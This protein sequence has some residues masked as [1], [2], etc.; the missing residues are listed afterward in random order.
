MQSSSSSSEFFAFGAGL[1]A[2]PLW[3]LGCLPAAVLADCALPGTARKAKKNSNSEQKRNNTHRILFICQE[4]IGWVRME[5]LSLHRNLSLHGSLISKQQHFFHLQKK[6]RM[7]IVLGIGSRVKHPEFGDGVV[8]QVKPATYKITFIQNG[9]RE[10]SE[11]RRVG[12][13]CR[14]RWSPYH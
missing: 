3:K 5:N 7:D 2:R 14:S 13:E 4:G 1:G 8:V 9:S 11:E 10:R 6:L 12:K